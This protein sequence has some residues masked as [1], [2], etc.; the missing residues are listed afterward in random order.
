MASAFLTLTKGQSHTT[1]SNVTYVEVSAF[2]E[3][4]F[5]SKRSPQFSTIKMSFNN[6]HLGLLNFHAEYKMHIINLHLHEIVST[7]EGIQ[8]EA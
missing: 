4:F 1:R 7:A 5:F 2:S 8:V 3:G 6:S